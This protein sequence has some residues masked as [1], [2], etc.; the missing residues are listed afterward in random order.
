MSFSVISPFSMIIDASDPM[1]AAKWLV[2]Q[3][4]MRDQSS[5]NRFIIQDRSNNKYGGHVS[6]YDKDGRHKAKI[7]LFPTTANDVN[8]L[9]YS[10]TLAAPMMA[11]PMMGTPMMG[12]PMMGTPMMGTT[13]GTPMMTTTMGTP[14]MAA[15]MMAGRP[16]YGM[17]NNGVAVAGMVGPGGLFMPLKQVTPAATTVA[18]PATATP[19]AAPTVAAPTVAAPTATTVAAP[20]SPSVHVGMATPFGVV[21]SPSVNIIRPVSPIFGMNVRPLSMPATSMSSL[22]M[23]NSRHHNYYGGPVIAPT[24]VL[25]NQN[26]HLKAGLFVGPGTNMPSRP[27][28]MFK[29]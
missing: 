20:V 23:Y 21:A 19:V 26:P 4:I 5:L 1:S 11:A 27:V 8:S 12:T 7:N 29:P 25:I 3:K 17:D 28:M 14:M 24:P 10:P 6:F 18:A 16:I 13:M 2:N 22:P 9:Y 15:P